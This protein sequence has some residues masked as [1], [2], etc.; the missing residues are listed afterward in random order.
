PPKPDI[1]R[2]RAAANRR[3]GFEFIAFRESGGLPPI[4]SWAASSGAAP[5]CIGLGSLVVI[6]LPPKPVLPPLE[7]SGS[8]RRLPIPKQPNAHKSSL[9][10]NAQPLRYR[11]RH[12]IDAGTTLGESGAAPG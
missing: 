10:R 12:G 9:V 2:A 8:P 1:V 6:K 5:S 11:S 7:F 4:A 3:D